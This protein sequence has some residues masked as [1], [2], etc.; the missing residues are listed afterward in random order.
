MRRYIYI[1]VICI[2]WDAGHTGPLKVGSV[3]S[4]DKQ[5]VVEDDLHVHLAL[6]SQSNPEAPIGELAP[7]N[8]S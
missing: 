5:E 8:H 3:S 2:C 4:P 1:Y 6:T 7:V